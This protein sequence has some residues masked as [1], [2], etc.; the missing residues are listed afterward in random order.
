[1][2]NYSEN[3]LFSPIFAG[4]SASQLPEATA[5]LGI[6]EKSFARDELILRS[7]E[8]TE[9]VG[10][11][12]DGSVEV[13]QDDFW[14]NRSVIAAL[15]S[16]DCFAETFAA[17]GVPLTVDVAAKSACRIAFFSVSGLL[18]VSGECSIKA[19][20]EANFIRLL[21][22]K[23]LL[24]N[25]RQTHMSQRSTREK[26]LSYLSSQARAAGSS[27]FTIPMNRQQLADFLAVDRSGLSTALSRLRDEGVVE[28][29]GSTFRLTRL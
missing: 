21:A 11:I 20:M 3:I 15:S 12:I 10:V 5:C 6:F 22:Q 17:A 4:I 27:A 14:G 19:L 18:S 8:P 24:L 25:E 9:L 7:G 1:M 16:G 23:N 2:K 28:S 13:R 29:D 26:L